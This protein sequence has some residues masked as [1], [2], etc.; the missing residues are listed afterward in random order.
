MADFARC[1]AG[2]LDAISIEQAHVL[3]Q[4]WGG[5]LAQEFYRLFPECVES[6][7]LVDTYAGWTGSFGVEIVLARLESCLQQSRLSAEEWIPDWMPDLFA[8][9]A[10]PALRDEMIGI[11][12]DFHAGGFRTMTRALAEVEKRDLLP[13]IRVPTLLIWGKSDQRSPVHVVAQPI[14]AAIPGA[15]LTVIPGAGHMSVLEQPALVNA[16]VRSFLQELHD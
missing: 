8:D 9:D 16:A 5:V 14:A 4:S 6:L 11:M 3:G 12:S 15:N 2:F 13:N 1:L 10:P 7:I